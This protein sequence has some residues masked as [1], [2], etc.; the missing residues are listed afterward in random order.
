M[1]SFSEQL[2]MVPR[3]SEPKL[4]AFDAAEQEPV[5]LDASVSKAAPVALERVVA[6]ALRQGLARARERHQALQRGHVAPAL[7]G[8][9]HVAPERGGG[10]GAQHAARD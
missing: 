8:P 7:L 1:P 5:G 6:A 3:P 4:L 10:D 9:L 2:G